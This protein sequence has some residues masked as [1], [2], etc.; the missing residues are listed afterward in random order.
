MHRIVHLEAGRPTQVEILG[1]KGSLAITG[2]P[3]AWVQT[4]LR[5]AT[6][7]PVR[8]ELL[9]GDYTL[10]FECPDGRR[11]TEHVNIVADVNTSTS[12]NCEKP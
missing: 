3:W 12:I 8:W 2:K 5:P 9:E 4:G 6:E 10:R 1:R 7:T 11:K